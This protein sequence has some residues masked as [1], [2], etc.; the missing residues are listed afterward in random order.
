[1]RWAF[2]PTYIRKEESHMN[3]PLGSQALTLGSMRI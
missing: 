1:M 3:M 2:A